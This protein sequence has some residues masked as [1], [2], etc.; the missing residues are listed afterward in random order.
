VLTPGK[1]FR[2]ILQRYST[3]LRIDT[4]LHGERSGPASY[5]AVQR[6]NLTRVSDAFDLA[7]RDRVIIDGRVQRALSSALELIVCKKDVTGICDGIIKS[8]VP[9]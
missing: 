9:K 4:T 7:I 2:F 3:I 6:E 1:R 5:D 8:S